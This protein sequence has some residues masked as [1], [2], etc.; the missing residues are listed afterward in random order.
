MCGRYVVISKITEIEERFGVHANGPWGPNFNIG[1]GTL[2]PVITNDK[3]KQLQFFQF[4]LTPFWARKKMYFF[5]ARAEGD[6]NKENDPNYTGS[7]G[8]IKK[9]AFR[10]PIRSQRCLVVAD[11]FIE[12]TTSE[13]LDSPFVVHLAP[14]RRPFAIAG[15]WDEWLDKATGEIVHSF[16]IITT[17]PNKLLQKLPHHRSPVILSQ[18][19]EQKW[20]DT[21]RPLSDITALL[22]PY[23]EE[24]MNA[25]PISAESKNPRNNNKN[26]L[27]PVG[28][29]VLSEK[30]VQIEQEMVLEG[31]GFT[32]SRSR[33]L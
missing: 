24:G 21:D 30:K 31:M 25:Y 27:S 23:T 7:L 14:G 4:G 8:I 28:P 9:P 33:R 26:L 6:H 2:A 16:A 19:D 18:R 20:L 32:R 10:K 17:T 13:K 15:L 1:P 5:N 12:G 29:P 3:P 11:C 22:K